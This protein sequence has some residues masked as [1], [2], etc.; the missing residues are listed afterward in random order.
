M[1]RHRGHVI[2]A[3][4]CMFIVAGAWPGAGYQVFSD[5]SRGS[6]AGYTFKFQFGEQPLY[7]VIETEFRDSGG[8][9][10][11]ISYTTSI[12]DRRS[13]IQ[14]RNAAN[15]PPIGVA[16]SGLVSLLWECDRYEAREQGMKEEAVYDSLRH[17]FAPGSLHELEA[18]ADSKVAFLIN[19]GS[20]EVSNITVTPGIV[21]NA[22]ARR[23]SPS[24]TVEKCCMTQPNMKVLLESL[25]FVYFPDGPRH[26]GETWDRTTVEPQGTFGV[27]TTTT[28]TK[29]TSVKKVEGRDVA[30]IDISSSLTLKA[31]TPPAPSAPGVPPRILP[32]RQPGLADQHAQLTTQPANVKGPTI[33]SAAATATSGPA[34]TRPAVATAAVPTS[35]PAVKNNPPHNPQQREFR[36]EKG[37][38]SGNIEFDLTRGEVVQ[39]NLRR[40]VVF[41]ADVESQGMGKMQLRSGTAQTVHIK[42]SQTPPPKPVIVG[43]KVLPKMSD[44]DKESMALAE[45][46]RTAS[47]QPASTQPVG[48]HRSQRIMS[49]NSPS[50][51]R[52]PLTATRRAPEQQGASKG[53]ATKRV[54]PPTPTSQPHP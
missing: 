20:G 9:P 3:A 52:E 48:P 32:V 46:A 22:V 4:V 29:L 25:G 11:L 36:L 51:G 17:L 19:P 8:V 26:I 35:G 45:K 6:D 47:T 39:L 18:N 50:Q 33:K 38:F 40:E 54:K 13:I 23:G 1:I 31:N 34:T 41:V 15:A 14:R 5:E 30:M 12:K 49:N 21:S 7:Y 10:P 44:A 16:G 28:H 27:L 2:F 43:G 24:K 53:F 37:M 42:S